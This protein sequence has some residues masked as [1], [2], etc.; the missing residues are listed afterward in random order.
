MTML[1]LDSADEVARWLIRYGVTPRQIR[2]WARRGRIT[3]YPGDRYEACEVAD[4]LDNRPEADR[5]RAMRGALRSV[6]MS[7]TMTPRDASPQTG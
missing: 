7:A 5:R 2:D 4:Y 6:T 3:R 1:L